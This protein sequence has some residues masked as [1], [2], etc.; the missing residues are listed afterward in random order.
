MILGSLKW[1]LLL[2][3]TSTIIYLALGIFIG[4]ASAWVR[5]GKKDIGLLVSILTL[6]SIPSFFLGI[7]FVI[8]FALKCGI[9][10]TSG[11][12]TIPA[13]YSNPFEEITDILYHLI[14][15][16]AT[17]I[18]SHIGGT[19]LL[20]RNSMLG[21]LGDD[22]I[23]TARAKGISEQYILYKHALKNA[24]LPIV[25]MSALTIGFMITSTIFVERVFAYPG[26]GLM[27]FNAVLYHD[28]PLLQGIFLFITIAVI[29]TNFIA[30]MTYGLL[31]PRLRHA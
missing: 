22:Y 29:G 27:L 16:A 4:A 21:V 13:L 11:A 26:I 5:G 6:S 7:L 30:D 12:Y 9:F 14:L 2:T 17:L 23:L 8:F 20:M 25:T 19:Y 18:S 1:T 24:L 3:I 10:P 28:Y 31:D 15:P